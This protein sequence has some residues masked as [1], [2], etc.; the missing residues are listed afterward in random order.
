MYARAHKHKHTSTSGRAERHVLIGSHLPKTPSCISLRESSP[1][2]NFIVFNFR[3]FQKV[4]LLEVKAAKCVLVPLWRASLLGVQRLLREA[5]PPWAGFQVALAA[6]YL[7]VFIGFDA[8]ALTWK[9]PI[10][11]YTSRCQKLLSC[12]DGLHITTS[13]YNVFAV[14]VTSFCSQL[15]SLPDDLLDA[16]Q[17]YVERL[18][19]GPHQWLPTDITFNLD[20]VAGMPHHFR[21]L[22]LENLTARARVAMVSCPSAHHAH[23]HI[24]GT[25]WR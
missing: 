25:R 13:L 7:G 21:N 24:H 14:S 19:H 3:E 8:L 4:S 22:R 16:E 2:N 17:Y 9:S 10:A 12:T 18:T 6:K 23:L 5:L 11:K 20:L 15:Y 1:I